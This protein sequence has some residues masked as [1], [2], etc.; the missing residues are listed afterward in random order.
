MRAPPD[1]AAVSL[2]RTPPSSACT[3]VELAD[4]LTLVEIVSV[5]VTA[6]ELGVT[7]VGLKLQVA[8]AG[9]PEQVSEVA[10]ANP[11][12]G[13]TV[14]VVVVVPPV[15]I[16]ADDGLVPIAKSAGGAEMVMV[17]ADETAAP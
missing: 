2:A 8:F 4:A 15:A 1:P 12:D 5:D 6:P 11:L 3:I 14:M 16:D 7:L 17:C 10:E 9:R 13:V